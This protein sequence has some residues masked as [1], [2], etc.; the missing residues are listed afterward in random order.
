M[1]ANVWSLQSLP[2][3]DI[4]LQILMNFDIKIWQRLRFY[5]LK[6]DNILI[7]NLHN[8]TIPNNYLYIYNESVVSCEQ[9]F[10][11]Y[12]HCQ[13]ISNYKFLWTLISKF[14]KGWDF[15]NLERQHSNHKLTQ[16]DD[17]K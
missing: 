4:Q 15:M 2:M 1:W 5:E 11:V 16:C 6:K 17:F 8:V 10:E 7:I 3:D 9:M 14:D 13:W 12:N